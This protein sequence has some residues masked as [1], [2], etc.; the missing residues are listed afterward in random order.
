MAENQEPGSPK[1]AGKDPSELISQAR[2][3]AKYIGEIGGSLV[4]LAAETGQSTDSTLNVAKSLGKAYKSVANELEKGIDSARGLERATKAVKDVTRAIIGLEVERASL[5]AELNA[6]AMRLGQVSEETKK[7]I[8]GQLQA[9]ADMEDHV[10]HMSEDMKQFGTDVKRAVDVTKGFSE[11]GEILGKLPV[12]GS[13]LGSAFAAAGT[14]ALKVFNETNDEAQAKAA[15]LQGFYNALGL[16]IAKGLVDNLIKASD[17]TAVIQKDLRVGISAA[18]D[19]AKA[20][21]DYADASG[22]SRINTDRLIQA[23]T[24]LNKVL[25]TSVNFTE[26]EKENFII[27]TKYLGISAESY[28]KIYAVAS[29]V[30]KSTDEYRQNLTLAAKQAG[31]DLKIRL[32]SSQIADK[33][34]KLSYETLINFK[35]QDAALGQAVAKAEKYGLDLEK[36]KAAGQAMLNFEQSI[37]D[38]LEAELLTGRQLNLERARAAALTGDQAV[39]Q[40][41]IYKQAGSLNEFTAMNVIQRES[42]AKALG[43]NVEQMSEMLLRQE[44]MNNLGDK[45]AKLNAQDLATVKSKMDTQNLTAAQAYEQVEAE[46]SARERFADSMEK[47][48]TIFTD[49]MQSL[50][51]FLEKLTDGIK[52][53]AESGMLS[54]MVKSLAIGGAVLGGA[55]LYNTISKFSQG[56][57][58]VQK[59]FVVNNGAGGAGGIGTSGTSKMSSMLGRNL[60]GGAKY[61]QAMRMSQAG[62]Y[63]LSRGMGG[64]MGLKGVGLG[65]VAGLA[66]MGLSSLGDSYEE[67][68][69][70]NVGFGVAGGAL[71]GAGTGAMIGSII[72]G[73]GTVAGAGI[74]AAIGGLTAYLER[75][76]K[77]DTEKKSEQKDHY[78]IMTEQLRV[79]A[80]KE[81]QLYMDSNKVGLA[82]V[83]G[84]PQLGD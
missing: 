7:R 61:S 66:G 47:I 3:A 15:G 56:L 51:P 4:R 55:A 57:L 10:K 65:A 9:V 37:G 33:I 36:V 27:S 53:F 39:L 77:E 45:A 73:I 22:D 13:A 52:Y 16:I 68:S 43:L 76:D 40:E 60:P 24:E 29:A 64:A 69:A 41:E 21:R 25:G 18:N 82:L 11:A 8:I 74:G 71:S 5:M 63:G 28:G 14:K 75:K 6:E 26:Q 46:I 50:T 58:G 1:F 42:L 81:T 79:I 67:G 12:I 62:K 59:V 2:D 20:S 35:G 44:M 38:E 17:R 19:I 78:E 84:N 48:K 23:N 34:S 32:T 30:G 54:A 31:N 72:P 80:Q 49:V 83:Q 70:G